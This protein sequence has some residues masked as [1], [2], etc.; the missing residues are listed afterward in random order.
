[1]VFES[2]LEGDLLLLA[3]LLFGAVLAFQGMNHFLNADQMAGY[4]GMKGVPLPGVA[5]VG[6]GLILLGGGLGIVLGVF[7]TIAAGALAVFFLVT[8][9]LMHDFWAVDDEQAQDEMIQFL[10]NA[11]LFGASVLFLAI[12]GTE[13]AYSLGIG[14]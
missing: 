9:P 8:T 3:R 10:K 5:V 1:M 12:S 7:P 6:T 2:G 11:E 14:L 13:W 4:A